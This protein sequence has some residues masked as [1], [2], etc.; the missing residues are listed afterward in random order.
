[1]H[2]SSVWQTSHLTGCNFQNLLS[3]EENLA[4]KSTCAKAPLFSSE[5]V[6]ELQ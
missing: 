3:H 2:T 6:R 5:S 1:M 4:V